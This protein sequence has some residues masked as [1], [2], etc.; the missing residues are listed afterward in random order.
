MVTFEI[1][2]TEN[3]SGLFVSIEIKSWESVAERSLT[4]KVNTSMQKE[5]G[6]GK[7]VLGE[8]HEV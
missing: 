5:Q 8:S 3:L 4:C 1:F 2:V 6:K 7:H